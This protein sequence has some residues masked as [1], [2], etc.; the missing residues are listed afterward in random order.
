MAKFLHHQLGGIRIQRLRDGRHHAHPHQ[1]LDHVA[2]AR[3]HAVG[4]FLHRDRIRQ[5]NVAHDFHLIRAQPLQ[6]CLPPLPFALTA[7]GGERPDTLIFTLDRRL[8]VDPS[9]AARIGALLRDHRLRLA[10]HDKAARSANR[11]GLVL[12]LAR[13]RTQPQRF[14]RLGRCSRRHCRRYSR[15]S[16]LRRSFWRACHRGAS[17]FGC[18]SRF[19]RL[20]R[21]GLGCLAG[22]FYLRLPGFLF[23]R[24]AGLFLAPPR[25][26]R[27]GQDRDC[28]FLLAPLRLALLRLLTARADA[29]PAR[30]RSGPEARVSPSAA[31]VSRPAR[32]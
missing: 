13:A 11:P 23:R 25:F 29:P 32:S 21:H 18:R 20:P 19:G 5:N 26:L 28:R 7:H 24:L 10:R 31:P 22:C 9:G 8:N 15:S 12:I 6:F 16:R 27:R 4:Q 2:G 3:R 30:A 14:C 1:R 17:G